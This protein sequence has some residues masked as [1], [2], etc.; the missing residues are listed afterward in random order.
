MIVPPVT[1]S[2][3]L[4]PLIVPPNSVTSPPDEEILPEPDSVSVLVLYSSLTKNGTAV[5]E[6]AEVTLPPLITTTDAPAKASCN[7]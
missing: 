6:K 1:V 2:V 3:L 5:I 7:V 4:L